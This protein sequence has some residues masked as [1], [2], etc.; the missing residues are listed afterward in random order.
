MCFDSWAW[1][2]RTWS[3]KKP[4]ASKEYQ[5]TG[6]LGFFQFS[7]LTIQ[8]NGSNITPASSSDTVN[9]KISIRSTTANKTYKILAFDP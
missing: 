2:I 1:I 7:Q 9:R 3:Q 4:N 8:N 5:I 6:R